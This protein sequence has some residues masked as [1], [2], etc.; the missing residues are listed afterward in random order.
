MLISFERYEAL[1]HAY[2]ALGDV[3]PKAPQQGATPGAVIT[4]RRKG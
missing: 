4:T 3:R 1:R 2:D